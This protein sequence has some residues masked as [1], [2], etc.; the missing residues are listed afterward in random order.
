M[1]SHDNQP[2]QYNFFYVVE[3]SQNALREFSVCLS[4]IYL[5]LLYAQLSFCGLKMVL[6][7]DLQINKNGMKPK[8]PQ[9]N[10]FYPL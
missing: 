1:C 2:M 8:N 6:T 4:F 10:F 3:Q 7:S 5:H 9:R